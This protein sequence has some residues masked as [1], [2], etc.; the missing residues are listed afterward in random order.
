M[1][2]RIFNSMQ[3]TCVIGKN[4]VFKYENR[5]FDYLVFLIVFRLPPICITTVLRFFPSGVVREAPLRIA[6]FGKTM[7]C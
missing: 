5:R 3:G 2:V 1:L 4:V 6:G 7:F